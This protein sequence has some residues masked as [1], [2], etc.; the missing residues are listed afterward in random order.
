MGMNTPLNR[1]SS[2]LEEHENRQKPFSD[3]SIQ[4]KLSDEGIQIARRTIS[5]Y[6]ES[7]GIP[8]SRARKQ[9]YAIQAKN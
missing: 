5:K 4:K 7:I 8:S 1:Y 2:R 9:R 3:Q 6:R